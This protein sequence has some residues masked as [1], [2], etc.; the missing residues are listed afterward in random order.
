AKSESVRIRQNARSARTNR[1][2]FHTSSMPENAT[3]LYTLRRIVRR[4][5][6]FVGQAFPPDSPRRVRRESLTY[7]KRGC[8]AVG[9]VDPAFPL[10][11][12]KSVRLESLTYESHKKH[13]SFSL[14]SDDA[15]A[16]DPASYGLLAFRPN[17]IT[18]DR[19]DMMGRV[20][21]NCRIPATRNPG[22]PRREA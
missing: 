19:R 9:F 22:D 11:T 4:A 2:N 1:F 5:T 18:G 12:S 15:I 17:C 8:A 20:S 13:W 21:E 3:I 14:P 7:E 10:D 6:D 16:N